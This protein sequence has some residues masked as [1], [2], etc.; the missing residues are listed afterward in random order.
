MSVV[1]LDR[2][3]PPEIVLILESIP[4]YL[5]LSSNW[6]LISGKYPEMKN[7]KFLKNDFKFSNSILTFP[8]SYLSMV[9]NHQYLI[10][11]LNSH[12]HL[13]IEK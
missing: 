2:T 13:S 12:N 10:I 9:C 11:Y 7:L 5:I 1:K 8:F 4:K 6:D 3:F